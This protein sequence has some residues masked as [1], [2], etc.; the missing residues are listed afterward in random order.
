MFYGDN[1]NTLASSE[2]WPVVTE[3]KKEGYTKI[4]S[5]VNKNE[6]KLLTSRFIKVHW[7]IVF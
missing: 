2:L 1:I 6:V 4:G 7:R 3:Y 5:P